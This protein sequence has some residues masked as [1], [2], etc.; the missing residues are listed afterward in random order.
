MTIGASLNSRNITDQRYFMAAKGAGGFVGEPLG[1][2][3]IYTSICSVQVLCS[4]SNPGRGNNTERRA[5]P[6]Q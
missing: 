2:F 3:S 6:Y 5:S 4:R 1:V